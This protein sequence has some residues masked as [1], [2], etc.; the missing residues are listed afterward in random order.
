MHYVHA[1]GRVLASAPLASIS[2]SARPLF[3]SPSYSSIKTSSQLI[4]SYP[5]RRQLAN[6]SAHIISYD[7]LSWPLLIKGVHTL[8][9]YRASVQFA[10]LG[11][12]L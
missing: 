12:R 2:S 4:T 9:F 5:K 3:F 8:R 1:L 7:Y 10:F 11:S 6:P